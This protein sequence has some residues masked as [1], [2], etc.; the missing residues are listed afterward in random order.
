RHTERNSIGPASSAGDTVEFIDTRNDN[1]QTG[2]FGLIQKKNFE[3]NHYMVS[4]TTYF[5]KNNEFKAGVEYE[6]D[7]AD[8]TK[9]MSGGQQVI[10]ASAATGITLDKDFAPRLGVIWNPGRD[11]KTKVFGSFGIYYEEIPMDLVIRSFSF[12]RQPKVNNF[13]RTGIVPDPQADAI[14]DT[15]SGIFGGFTEPS[16]PDLENQYVREI[17]VGGEREVM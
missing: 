9:R 15:P 2:G 3:R 8:V 12:E 7:S 17:I 10:E 16:D 13:D 5:L 11:K 1:F 4:A 6:K 14:L